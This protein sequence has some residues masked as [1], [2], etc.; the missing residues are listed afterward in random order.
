MSYS[1]S[2]AVI[3]TEKLGKRV[4]LPEGELT[5]LGDIDL[6]IFPGEAVAVVGASGAG[7]STLIKCIAGTHAPDKGKILFE[8]KEVHLHTP[9]DATRLG[10]ET[11]YQ[12]KSLGEKQVDAELATL[13][14]CVIPIATLL[15]TS[16]NIAGGFAVT[17]RMLEMFRK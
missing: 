9:S 15:I 16:I 6:S 8:G 5:L 1:Q 3:V 14:I 12:D 7:K 10:I 17:R 4:M 2:P 11:V 13:L